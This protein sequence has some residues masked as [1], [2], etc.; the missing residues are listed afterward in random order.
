MDSQALVSFFGK[1]LRT[2]PA[3][4]KNGLK[5][6]TVTVNALANPKAPTIQGQLAGV[7]RPLEET[8][9]REDVAARNTEPNH[10][11]IT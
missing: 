2:H 8:S 6:E 5:N 4:L 7:S 3:V 9:E 11:W 10:N 1:P